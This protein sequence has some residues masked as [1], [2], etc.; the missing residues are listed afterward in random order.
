MAGALCAKAEMTAK[1]EEDMDR[2][3]KREISKES[4]V[5]ESQEML[6][7]VLKEFMNNREKIVEVINSSAKMG[8]VVGKC[9]IHSTDLVLMKSRDSAKIKCATSG[10]RIDF[11]VPT[12]ALVK[13]EEKKCPE[14]SLPLIRIIRK[15]QAP[16]TKC[17]DPGCVYNTKNSSLGKCP[18]SRYPSKHT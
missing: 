10:C 17:I 9:P 15:G 13:V 4:V 5:R 14:C 12:N 18:D 6:D 3:T 7:S 11:Y 1:L 2:I 16:E 8:D